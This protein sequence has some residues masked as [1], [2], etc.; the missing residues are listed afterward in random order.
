MLDLRYHGNGFIQVVLNPVTRM[1]IYSPD[2]NPWLVENARVHDHSFYFVSQVLTGFL[3]HSTFSVEAGPGVKD[4]VHGLYHVDKKQENEPLVRL[5]SCSS[6][7]IRNRIIHAGESYEFG[8]PGRFHDTWAEVPT[9]SI[10][11]KIATEREHT[12][13]VVSL[14]DEEPDDAFSRQPEYE[15]MADEVHRILSMVS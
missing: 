2:F 5:T 15:H 11:T 14:F 12:P 1:H 9:V 3:I 8:G 4:A 13:R 6:K 7:H 10:M